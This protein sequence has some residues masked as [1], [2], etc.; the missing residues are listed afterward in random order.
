MAAPIYIPTNICIISCLLIITILTDVK[1]HL[2]VILIC[3][4]LVISD[5]E[6]L[7]MCL[8]ATCMSSLEKYLFRSSAHPLI[9][10]FGFCY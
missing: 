4:F 3:I 5:A 6:Y 9:R 8:L 2:I 10:S 1:E 7:S